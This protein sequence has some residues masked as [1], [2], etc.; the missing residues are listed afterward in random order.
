M[1]TL[2]CKAV[3]DSIGKLKRPCRFGLLTMLQH[4]TPHNF[5]GFLINA[6]YELQGRSVGEVP[7]SY[8]NAQVMG[9]I[10]VK[11]FFMRMIVYWLMGMLGVCEYPYLNAIFNL[12]ESSKEPVPKRTNPRVRNASLYII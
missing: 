11:F 3:H 9:F 4:A 2:I 7:L 5:W 8:A 1:P 12:E 10:L 6:A